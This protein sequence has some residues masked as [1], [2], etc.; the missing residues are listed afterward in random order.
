MFLLISVRIDVKKRV[1]YICNYY[2]IFQNVLYDVLRKREVYY[3][4]V[5]LS[6]DEFDFIVDY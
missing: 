2:F 6:Y 1:I 4:Y 3:V 5:D